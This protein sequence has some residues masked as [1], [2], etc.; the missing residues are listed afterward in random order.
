MTVFLFRHLKG[1]RT[2][3]VIAILMTVLQVGLT[4]LLPFPIRFIIDKV[5]DGVDPDVAYPILGGTLKFF[6]SFDAPERLRELMNGEHST[7]GVILFSAT[8]LL[9]CSLLS[10]LMSYFQ[11]YLAALVGQNLTARLRGQLFE[12]MQRLPLAW[13]SQQKHGDL[14]QRV[15]GD[16]SNI[17]KLVTDGLVDLLAGVLTIVGVV[18][19]MLLIDWRFTMFAIVIVPLLFL[20]ILR[21]TLDIKKAARTA[22]KVTGLV[23][24]VATE[25][26]GAIT[27]VKAFTLEQRE[28]ER[29]SSYVGRNREAALRSG[30][31]QARFTPLV[32]I[33]VALGTAFIIVVGAY[34]AAIDDIGVWFVTISQGHIT[35]GTLTVFLAYL[36]ML[37]QPMRNLSKLANVTSMAASGAERIQEVLDQ[38]PEVLESELPY[39]GP[40]RLR[41]EITY[42][43][44]CFGYHEEQ[45]VLQGI[46]LHIPAGQKIA[47]VGLSGSG[48]T[49]LVS[50]LLRFYELQ[51]G[52]IKIDGVDIG[53]YPLT[54]LRQNISLV[55]QDSVLFEGTIHE[56]IEIG[57]PGAPAEQIIDAARKAHIH[58]TIMGMPLGYETPVSEQGKNLSGGQRQRLA[59]AR[60]I[61]RDTPI[62]ILDEPTANLDVEAEA[63]VMHALSRL[64][65]GRTVIMISHR[66]NI[67][68]PMNEILV[69]QDGQ[70]AEQGSFQELRQQ[71][72]IFA[73]LLS[74]QNRYRMDVEV[75]PSMD[76]A[77]D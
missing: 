12:H 15:I 36:N 63:E 58:D 21:Y 48:K 68:G 66:L 46:D 20:L 52:N 65:V 16:I 60:A 29:F 76:L 28:A 35:I 25:D 40:T 32:A 6:D 38:S 62:L 5:K 49:T 7:F 73:R 31:L 42:E 47:L 23:A 4:L 45:A 39:T 30:I 56:N 43:R 64:I 59:I 34:V 72:G 51:S 70:I 11:L 8:M 17:E 26:I 53:H 27:E 50:L 19:I 75:P 61:L 9:V 77:S 55:L 41:G 13:H 74:E 22:A 37:Y 14:V 10:A 24:N 44:V 18:L 33:L 1:Y 2:L 54:V 57:R 67:L 69:L 3:I 71:D